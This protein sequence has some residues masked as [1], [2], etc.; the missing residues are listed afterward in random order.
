M[1]QGGTGSGGGMAPLEYVQDEALQMVERL[2]R[3][4]NPARRTVY[5]MRGCDCAEQG[6]RA[7]LYH[8]HAFT[9]D[10]LTRWQGAQADAGPVATFGVPL[11]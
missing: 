1:G 6:G 3:A 7:N 11:R 2:R 5:I 4:G 10:E 9:T 8:L